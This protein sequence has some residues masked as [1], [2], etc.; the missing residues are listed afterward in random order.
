[1]TTQPFER[2]FADEPDANPKKKGKQVIRNGKEVTISEAKQMSAEE[3]AAKFGQAYIIME[4]DPELK[5]WFLDFARR[6]REQDGN[7]SKEIFKLELNQRPWW[8]NNSAVYIEDLKKELENPL[9]YKQ[10]LASDV[11]NLKAQA[12]QVG[13]VIDDVTAELLAKNA[14]RLSWNSQQTLNK[15]ADYITVTQTGD[16]AGL[17]GTAQTDISDWARRNGIGLSQTDVV[18]YAREIATGVTSLDDVKDNLRRTYMM[19]AYPG[20]SDRIAAGQDIYD[21]ASPYRFKMANL[22]EVDPDAIDLNDPLLQRGLQGVGA[23]GKPS[24]VPLYEFERQVREDP[25]WQYTDN[26]YAT[27]TDVGT[28][29]LQMFGF[30]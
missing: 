11:A 17:A 3:I 2:P 12:A 8:Q 22:L 5:Q 30:R 29:L 24:V 4:Q 1:M 28:Q 14:R 7:I 25:R 26:A 13:A 18:R 23:D 15:L 10:S 21:I 19:G 20:W 6:Y 9:D 16:L 27:D